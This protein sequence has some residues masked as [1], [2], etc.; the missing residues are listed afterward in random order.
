ML[1]DRQMQLLK[2]TLGLDHKEMPYRNY[3]ATSEDC[4]V[5]KNLKQLEA[6]GYMFS[7]KRNKPSQSIY[8]YVTE[9]GFEYL[10][11]KLNYK[12]VMQKM[13]DKYG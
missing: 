1:T 7:E 12:K 3:F 2:H 6:F 8:F 11:G 9:K 4:D 10:F 13:K 5:Y